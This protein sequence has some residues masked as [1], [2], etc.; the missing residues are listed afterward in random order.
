MPKATA[1][2]RQFRMFITI[3]IPILLMISDYHSIAD[4]KSSIWI[5]HA[6]LSENGT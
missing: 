5:S 1:C 6:T 4:T 3:I 2:G